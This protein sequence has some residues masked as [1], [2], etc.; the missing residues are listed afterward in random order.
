[1]QT[2]SAAANKQCN[3]CL[4]FDGPWTAEDIYPKWLRKW[5][6]QIMEAANATPSDLPQLRP[7]RRPLWKPVCQACQRTLNK[8][9]EIPAKSLMLDLLEHAEL[10]LNP[11]QQI[12][13]ASWLIKTDIIFA[14]YRKPPFAP[15]PEQ[16]AFLRAQLVRMMQD[17]TPPPNA[18]ARIAAIKEGDVPAETPRRFLPPEWPNPHMSVVSSVSS[19]GTLVSETVIGGRLSVV[20]YIEAT[21]NDDRFVY[22]WPPQLSD[23]HWPP[24]G[25]L[26]FY[27][28]ESLRDEWK[29]HPD[30][31]IGGFFGF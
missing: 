10:P 22:V 14:L 17:G 18:T 28:V 21:Q 31:I 30:N 8:M 24:S 7:I 1:M 15:L 16:I 2:M 4:T 23:V 3:I 11:Q 6:L 29:Q 26:S 20:P 25:R 19:L 9:F 13:I 5:I 27:D 12:V